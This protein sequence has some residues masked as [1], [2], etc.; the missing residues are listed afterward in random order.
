MFVPAALVTWLFT[1]LGG[2]PA[3]MLFMWSRMD[4]KGQE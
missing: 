1:H 2:W 3:L 4:G